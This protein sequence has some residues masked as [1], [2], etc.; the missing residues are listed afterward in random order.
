MPHSNRSELK[1]IVSAAWDAYSD[2]RKAPH[3]RTAGPGFVDPDYE[4]A[5]DWLEAREK[6]EIAQVRHD[7]SSSP[8][9]ILLINGSSRTEHTCPGEM[10]KSWRLVELAGRV[11]EAANFAVEFST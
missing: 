8:S 3:T 4:I 11:F 6:I 5:L 1:A 10:S 9:S 2:G 7:D